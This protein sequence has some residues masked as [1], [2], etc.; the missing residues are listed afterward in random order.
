MFRSLKE[1]LLPVAP[2]DNRPLVLVA[3]GP[4]VSVSPGQNQQGSR[5]NGLVQEWSGLEAWK[6]AVAQILEGVSPSA[7]QEPGGTPVV[8]DQLRLLSVK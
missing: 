5:D 3:L 1:S 7:A 8:E 2:R 6:E 4:M